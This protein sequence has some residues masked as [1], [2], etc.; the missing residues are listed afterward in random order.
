M[1]SFAALKLDM[2]KA[3]DLV[4]WEFLAKMMAKLGFDDR[5]VQLIMKCI[6]TVSYR[7]SRH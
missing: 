7:I 6:S 2:S 4:E 3:Y 5:W 1:D